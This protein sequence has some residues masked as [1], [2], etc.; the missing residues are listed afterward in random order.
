M[1]FVHTFVVVAML[2]HVVVILRD[3]RTP[4]VIL[5]ERP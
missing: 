1:H 3:M 5:R 2:L 4:I